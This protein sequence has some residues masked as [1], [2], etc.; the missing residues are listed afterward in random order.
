MKK[1]IALILL[2]FL[3]FSSIVLYINYK[4]ESIINSI[5]SIK[6]GSFY[7]DGYF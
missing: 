1:G 6:L 5:P 2:Y 7:I 4:M 3:F